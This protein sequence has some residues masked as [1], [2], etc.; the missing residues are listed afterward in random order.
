MRISIY[1]SAL[2]FTGLF[3]QDTRSEQYEMTMQEM[4]SCIGKIDFNSL[5]SIQQETLR[6][7]QEIQAMCARGKRDQADKEAKLFYDKVMKLPA[8]MQMKVCT[9]GIIPEFDTQQR[10]HVCDAE[11]M[12]F[13]L[14]DTHRMNW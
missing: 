12:D 11:Q 9:K 7:K 14:P 3:A 8:I 5:S 2:L 1:L 4:Q 6:V 13:G 10:V